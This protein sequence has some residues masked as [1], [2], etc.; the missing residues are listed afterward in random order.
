[1]EPDA[2]E[3]APEVE[4]RRSRRRT[5]T[6]TAFRERGRV[7]VAI[8]A[9]FSRA[10]EAAWVERMV[11][12]LERTERRRRPSDDELVTRAARL[13]STYL[14]GAVRPTS[15]AWVGNQ[16]R[17]WGSCSPSNGSIRISDRLRGMPTW[18]LDY[19]LLHEL[20]H[21]VDAGHGPAFW[22]LLE[23]Y[24]H[25]ERARGFLSGVSFA[26]QDGSAGGDGFA[27]ADGFG[28]DDDGFGDDGDADDVLA[29]PRA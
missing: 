17:R 19:V 13:S 9:R 5:R 20:A 18:V 1:M 27:D 12:R 6:V 24:P 16:G 3:I 7:V 26:Q 22:A 11:A 14:G 15:V 25:T 8:P 29:G 2:A 4:V 10:E 21:L 28:D 23:G